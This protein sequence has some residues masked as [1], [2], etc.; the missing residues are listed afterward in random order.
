MPRLEKQDDDE[1]T[2][3]VDP[4]IRQTIGKLMI[5][6]MATTDPGVKLQATSTVIASLFGTLKVM[7]EKRAPAPIL[8]IFGDILHQMVE[9]T[10]NQTDVYTV[11]H[12]LHEKIM[13][14]Y[15]NHSE[16]KMRRD[17][18]IARDIERLKNC[19]SNWKVANLQYIQDNNAWAYSSNML[20]DIHP[21]LWEVA[22]LHKLTIMP[23]WTQFDFAAFANIPPS[24]PPGQPQ[25]GQPP[26]DMLPPGPEGGMPFA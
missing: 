4:E 7:L 2:F 9:S 11:L 15:E 10:R 19:M 1:E 5:I 3:Q 8:D 21:I 26:Q 6:M 16:G 17:L 13:S 22:I 25:G 12:P 18:Q 24:G 23:K 14:L 20:A